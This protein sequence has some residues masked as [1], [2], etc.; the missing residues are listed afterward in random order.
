VIDAGLQL[1]PFDLALGADEN[2]NN[3]LVRGAIRRRPELDIVRVQDAG[4]SGADDATVLEWAAQQ[5]RVLF[6]HDV[7]SMTRFA[8]ERVASGKPIPGISL[9]S[10][11]T[12][13]YL[14]P[15]TTYYCL[16]NAALK[17]NGKVRC[18][19]CRYVESSHA[20]NGKDCS[21]C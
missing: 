15:L 8:Y 5:S 6:T 16:P 12:Y 19:I 7:S 21:V 10:A 2:F 1:R 11:V 18:D 13:Q 9:K 20:I 14:K 17:E 3:D 4:L